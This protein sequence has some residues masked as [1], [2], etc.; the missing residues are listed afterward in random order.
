M[1]GVPLIYAL[2]EAGQDRSAGLSIPKL[3][4]QVF[5]TGLRMVEESPEEYIS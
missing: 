5:C 2:L 3:E 4:T 1:E